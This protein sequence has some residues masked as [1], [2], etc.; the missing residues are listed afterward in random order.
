MQIA[1]VGVPNGGQSGHGFKRHGPVAPDPVG[2]GEAVEREEL[3]KVVGHEERHDGEADVHVAHGQVDDVVVERR[4]EFLVGEDG[5]DDQHV[6]DDRFEQD[7]QRSYQNSHFESAPV[8]HHVEHNTVAAA[9]AAAHVAIVAVV[10]A[11]PAHIV[12][13]S[14]Q[15]IFGAGRCRVPGV[16]GVDL[17]ADFGDQLGPDDENI[18]IVALGQVRH[19]S[20]SKVTNGVSLLRR[21]SPP[22]LQLSSCSSI[23]K[24]LTCR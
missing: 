19:A 24:G 23:I 22:C 3:V 16:S 10:V 15:I 17:A 9:A 20:T 8:D 7:Q 13:Q 14:R 6:A 2:A 4:L 18:P 1:C 12:D 21:C 5:W 11:T